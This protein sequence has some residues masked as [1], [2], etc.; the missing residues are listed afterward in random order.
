MLYLYQI[1]RN[2]IKNERNAWF[3]SRYVHFE[4][5]IFNSTRKDL[6][7]V[8][9]ADNSWLKYELKAKSAWRLWRPKQMMSSVSTVVIWAVVFWE[10]GWHAQWRTGNMDNCWHKIQLV[11]QYGGQ[12]GWLDNQ[13][14]WKLWALSHY[15][16]QFLCG[17]NLCGNNKDS[18]F[19]KVL[20]CHFWPLRWG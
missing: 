14:Q 19:V 15:K 5:A 9:F 10:S 17:Q 11:R 6:T 16:K 20:K 8:E 18:I 3:L 12:Q 13:I 4:F 2:C 1:K 7:W